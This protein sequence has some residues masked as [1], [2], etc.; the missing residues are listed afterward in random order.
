MR[1]T[2]T[3][4]K[5]LFSEFQNAP[6]HTFIEYLVLNR[7]NHSN[8]STKQGIIEG[9][10]KKCPMMYMGR[11][12]NLSKIDDTDDWAQLFDLFGN[13][14]TSNQNEISQQGKLFVIFKDSSMLYPVSDKATRFDWNEIALAPPTVSISRKSSNS[15]HSQ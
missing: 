5:N 12:G 15:N 7:S 2:N 14:Q 1:A 4:W 8:G 9:F 10:L 6:R 13:N 11:N 3:I